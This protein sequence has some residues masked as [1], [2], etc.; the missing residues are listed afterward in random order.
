[1]NR[2]PLAF[3]LITT[4]CVQ[5]LFGTAQRGDVLFIRGVKYYIQ[6]NPLERY[7]EQNPERR[8]WSIELFQNLFIFGLTTFQ[9]VISTDL[10]RG[11]VASWKLE[12][13]KLILTDVQI[14][15]ANPL[16]FE[17]ATWR[18]VLDKIFP[19]Q[20]EVFAEWYSGHIIVPTG[21]LAKYV[22][23]GYASE[24]KSYLIYWLKNGVITKE[25]R[26]KRRAFK[27]FRKAQFELFKKTDK[28]RIAWLEERKN[29]DNA[30]LSDRE[31]EEF[32]FQFYTEEIMSMMGESIR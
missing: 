9:T 15:D 19:G 21:K 30:D 13:S 22:H 32:L 12:D 17:E 29:P 11:Y 3:L 28:Y 27:K 6:T 24:Y 7:F 18:S 1:V 25:W 20:R 2:A 14:Q 5:F 26:G 31:L 10:W 8:P 16:P 4:I 23:M